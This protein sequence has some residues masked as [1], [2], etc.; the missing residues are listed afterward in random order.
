MILIYYT[1][2]NTRQ[3]HSKL[4]AIL[5]PID[6]I[7]DWHV[8]LEDCDKVLRIISAGD[9]SQHISQLLPTLGFTGTLMLKSE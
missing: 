7:E 8:D 5:D 1:N 6:G 4:K 2:I 3:D 9:L